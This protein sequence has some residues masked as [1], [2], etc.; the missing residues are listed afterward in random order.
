[1]WKHMRV[2]EPKMM[3]YKKYMSVNGSKWMYMKAFEA[4]LWYMNVYESV[5][6]YMK[7]YDGIW[8]YMIVFDCKW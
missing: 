8:K 1:M 3:V 5:W 6:M 4:I 2:Y 7:Q